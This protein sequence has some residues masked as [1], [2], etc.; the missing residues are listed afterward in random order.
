MCKNDKNKTKRT[1]IGGGVEDVRKIGIALWKS[2]WKLCKTRFINENYPHY[3]QNGLW[4]NPFWVFHRKIKFVY[5]E[6]INYFV[7]SS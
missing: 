6:K 3:P 5:M 2:L 4:K 7:K 1:A